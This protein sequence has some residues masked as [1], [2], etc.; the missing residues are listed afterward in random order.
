MSFIVIIIVIIIIIIAVT[1]DKWR[2]DE[3]HRQENRRR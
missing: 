2:H 1:A 3:R